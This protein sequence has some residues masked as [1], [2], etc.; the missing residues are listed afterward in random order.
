MR[1][2]PDLIPINKRAIAASD[3][4]TKVPEKSRFNVAN[5]ILEKIGYSFLLKD[6]DQTSAS[7]TN[8]EMVMDESFGK[9]NYSGS[10][11][12]E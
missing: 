7:N 10:S 1:P 2:V 12:D 3:W 9:L 8:N 5:F 4:S 11:D 6:K